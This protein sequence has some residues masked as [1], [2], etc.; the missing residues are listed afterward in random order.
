[1]T[2]RV[3]TFYLVSTGSLVAAILGT[4]FAQTT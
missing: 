4:Q 2:G 3:S 1:M